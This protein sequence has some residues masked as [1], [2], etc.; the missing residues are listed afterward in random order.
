[1]TDHPSAS[2]P[3]DP[4]A[5]AVCAACGQ[6]LGTLVDGRCPRCGERV[7][8]DDVTSE[9]HTPYAVALAAGES[10]WRTMWRWV[11][12][13]PDRRLA[14]LGLARP[15]AASRRF[16]RINILLFAFLLALTVL[17][18][19]PR[20][21]HPVQTGPGSIAT[22]APEGKGWW[23]VIDRSSEKRSRF[24]D[25]AVVELWWNVPYAVIVSSAALVGGILVSF[26]VLGVVGS[27]AERTLMRAGGPATG[28]RCAVHY[29]TAWIHLL[30][31]AAL[32]LLPAPLADIAAV[33]GWAQVSPLIFRGAAVL[34]AVA[35]VC[36]WWFWLIRLGQATPRG[37]RRR[38]VRYFLVGAPFWVVLLGGGAVYGL[39]VGAAQIGPAL[40][41]IE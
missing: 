2:S 1:M 11:V 25:V 39:Y 33:A 12:T 21:W 18:N 26:L 14:H 38:A 4:R 36:L 32:L 41:L 13:A 27:R 9:D 24:D 5:W 15:S 40:G 10:G 17:V 28:L 3:P 20:A 23:Q 8:E 6:A 19:Y 22:T 37:V 34:V 30:T 7:V 29:G 31:L 16:A 35:G